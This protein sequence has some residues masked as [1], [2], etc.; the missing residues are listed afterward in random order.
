MTTAL[1][2]DRLREEFERALAS[3]TDGKSLTDLRNEWL[4]KKGGRIV[5]ALGALR[6]LAADL[7]PAYG[8]KVNR[9]KQEVER[10]VEER[11]ARFR[12]EETR[13][14]LAAEAVDPTLPGV[15][16]DRGGLHPL[17][18]VQQEIEDVFTG[19]GYTIMY[20]PDVETEYHNFEALN[21]PADHPARDAQDTFYVQGGLVLRTHTSPVQIRTML[22]QPPPV[23]IICPGKVYRC[24]M[25]ASHS[26]MF[27][28]VEALVVDEGITLGDLKGTIDVFMKRLLGERVKVRLR[29]SFFP[30]TEP[31]AEVDIS[32]VICTASGCPACKGTGWMEVMG[33]GMVHPAVF[34]AV[35][36]DPERWTGF[37]FGAG[38]DRLAMLKYGIPHLGILFENDVRFLRQFR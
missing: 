38:I 16:P 10:A 6:D 33:S 27:H 12:E 24:D 1:D 9:L 23:R 28:Q 2:L 34:E 31:S 15:P 30:F 26:P 19:L 13:R 18:L 35:G 37:A 7:K 14:R 3:V 29:P 32:C 20:G 11:A 22:S 8:E 36:Y 25:D 17:R 21:I 5:Q 4:A